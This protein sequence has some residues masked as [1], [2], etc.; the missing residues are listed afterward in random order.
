MYKNYWEMEYNPF[1]KN[2]GEKEIK[3]FNSSD[4]INSKARLEHLSKL[5][6]IGLLTGHSGTGKTYVLKEF[7]DNLNPSLYKV[8]YI[9]LSTVTVLEFYKSLAYGLD[10]DPPNKKVDIFKAIQERIINLVKDRGQTCLIIIDEAQYLQT[11]I[12]NDLKILL[13]F[14]MDSKDYVAFI[15]AGQPLLNNILTKKVH[16]ALKQRIIM[17]YNCQGI[18]HEEGKKYIEEK[19]KECGVY[20]QIITDSALEAIVSSGNGSIRKIN[21]MVDKCLFIGSISNSK[22]IDTDIVMNAQN[23]IELI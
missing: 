23:E 21:N 11:D 6:G 22:M 1:Q 20:N 10:L 7:T 12:L 3:T 19:L 5:G 4:Y 9:P 18:T 8:V 16:E 14:E 15:L 17:N 13:N 2:N